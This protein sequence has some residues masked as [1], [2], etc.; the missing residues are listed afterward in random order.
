MAACGLLVAGAAGA[1]ED[2]L[3]LPLAMQRQLWWIEMLCVLECCAAL[4]F[5]VRSRVCG[6]GQ[7]LMLL[8]Q[9]V[10]VDVRGWRWRGGLSRGWGSA[11]VI[12]YL[13]PVNTVLYLHCIY[14]Y[15]QPLISRYT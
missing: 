12:L 4:D 5:K 11:I 3:V 1:A 14:M 6:S 9:V 10:Q 8:V 2:C 13:A 15:L 7:L